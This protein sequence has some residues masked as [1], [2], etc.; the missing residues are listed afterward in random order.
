MPDQTRAQLTEEIE[1]LRR[2]LDK[3]A[4]RI[5][6]LERISVDGSRPKMAG[7][8]RLAPASPLRTLTDSPEPLL[9]LAT[10]LLGFDGFVVVL[11]SARRIRFLGGN[12]HRWWQR[13]SSLLADS[14]WLEWIVPEDR[15]RMEAYHQGVRQGGHE[16]GPAQA[17]GL[18]LRFPT[19]KTEPFTVV[20]RRSGGRT[21]YAARP[22][23]T[24]RPEQA[25]EEIRRWAGIFA[26]EM[27]QP[28]AALLTTAQ[29]CLS[30][31]ETEQ[32]EPGEITEA[33]AALVRRASYAGDVVRRLREWATN[34]PPRR[35]RVDLNAVVRSSVEQ[36]QSPL[37]AVGV[38]VQF[39]AKAELP[40]VWGDPVQLQQVTVNLVRNAL[41]AMQHVTPTERRLVLRT[42]LDAGEAVVAVQ[43]QGVGLSVA[44]VERLFTPLV[45]TKP[46]GMGLGLAI[47]RRLVEAHGGRLWVKPNDPHGCI[48]Y[49]SLPGDVTEP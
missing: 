42:L 41:E 2:Q 38:A 33:L 24:G 22:G 46:Q 17:I 30:L 5:A 18:R 28:L 8:S 43:D 13:K 47:S 32:A 15:E 7:G 6:R 11:D 25:S 3:Q 45:S 4:R 37:D 19:G 14:D 39:D 20:G 16:D 1:R 23:S 26:H 44:M 35:E 34:T 27:N 12:Y 21:W 29:A 49:Y 10:E 36:L 48:F 31:T 40:A 9:E